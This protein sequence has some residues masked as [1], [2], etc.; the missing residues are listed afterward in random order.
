MFYGLKGFRTMP[1]SLATFVAGELGRRIVN[2][3]YREGGL[4]GDEEKLAE[5]YRVS[6]TAIRDAVKILSG[7]GLLEARRGVGTVVKPRSE[8]GLLDNDVLAWHQSAPP[9]WDYMRQLME[10]RLVFEPMAA[11]WAAERASDKDIESIRSAYRRMEE[12]KGLV[13]HFIFAD[14]MFH[15]AILNSTGNAFMSAIE[16]VVFSALLASIKLTNVDPRKNKDSIPFHRNVADAIEARDAE[17]A[18]NRM[19]EL[20][21]DASQR[22]KKAMV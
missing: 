16:G 7:K 17:L 15:R 9:N 20:L 2:G 18:K 8:W 10:V 1:P 3:D 11:Y 5:H 14:A 6:R 12:E 13:E 22:L 4:I 19:E 21:A